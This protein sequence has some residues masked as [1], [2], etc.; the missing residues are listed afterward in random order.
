MKPD[1]NIALLNAAQEIINRFSPLIDDEYEKSRLS[2]W[3]A[4]IL[5]SA[6]KFNDSSS[7]LNQENADILEWLLKFT[8]LDEDDISEYGYEVTSE[9]QDISLMDTDNQI[10]R[11]LLDRQMIVLEGNGDTEG[12]K[13]SYTLMRAMHARRKVSD[14][15]GLLQQS[16]S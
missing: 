10:L 13:A 4:I 7:S 14:L 8:N 1:I 12:L 3:G 16:E 5:I 11:G 15:V 2:S 6:M 9:I